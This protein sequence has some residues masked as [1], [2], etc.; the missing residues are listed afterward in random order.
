[1]EKNK[2]WKPGTVVKMTS[3][4]GPVL[5][6]NSYKN[7]SDHPIVKCIYFNSVSG[8]HH[9]IEVHEDAIVALKEREMNR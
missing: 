1:M 5:T 8:Q 6:V 4:M 7:L 3:G 2:K 9:E